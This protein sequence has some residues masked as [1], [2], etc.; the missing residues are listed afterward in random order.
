MNKIRIGL[1]G[2]GM[3]G[4]CYAAVFSRDP[5]VEITACCDPGQQKLEKFA[6]RYHISNSYL[7]YKDLIST[8]K[9][10]V[11]ANAT[12]DNLHAEVSI[13]AM[14]KGLAVFSEK[15]MTSNIC[16]ADD[17]LRIA[18][19]NRVLTGINFSKRSSAA[20]I[21]AKEMIENNELGELRHIEGTYKQ[22][23]IPTENYGSWKDPADHSWTWRL[24]SAHQPLGVLGD[25]GSHL[26]DMAEFL[27]GSISDISCR[28]HSFNKGY[29][30]IGSFTL[31]GWDS[32]NSSVNFSCGANGLFHATRWAAGDE[33]A[34][35]IV[36]HGT[37]G[38]LKIDYN[39]KNRLNLFL[40]NEGKWEIFDLQ[41]PLNQYQK[42]LNCVKNNHTYKPDYTDG[43]RNQMLLDASLRSHTEDRTISI[44][45]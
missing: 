45:E 17:L 27:A 3:M 13:Q 9:L 35:S 15:P 12:P 36:V 24:S 2:C 6:Q 40:I 43:R 33:D 16:E 39:A 8:E 5:D 38:S 42:F 34:L 14:K 29:E 11:V 21:R 7:D 19:E 44:P 23:W 31:D 18:K 1:I 37:E 10:D 30:K 4:N 41:K 26:Y 22:G 32:F 25:L 20:L 28:M